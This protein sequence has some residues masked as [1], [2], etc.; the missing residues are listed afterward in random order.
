MFHIAGMAGSLRARS[1]NRALLRAAAALAPEGVEIS[2]FDLAPLPLYNADL[3]ES[4]S[5]GPTPEPVLSLRAVIRDADALLLAVTEYN[6]GVS[7]VLK[8]AIDWASRPPATSALV[9][10]PIGLIG[11]SPGPAGTGRAQLQLRQNF[12]F[13]RSYVLVEPVVTLGGA[14]ALFDVDLELVDDEARAAVRGLIEA[15]V[16]WAGQVRA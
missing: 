3:D 8:N 7:G 9:H 11:T 6:W 13:T 15:L 16:R 4:A 12:L 2:I 10:K 1:Y 5:G 14:A